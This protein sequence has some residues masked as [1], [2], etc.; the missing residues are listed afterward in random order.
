MGGV[1]RRLVYVPLL[2]N[3]RGSSSA[4]TGQ[5]A[6]RLQALWVMPAFLAGAIS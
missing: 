3:G 5:P 4:E 2:L 6:Q 1:P